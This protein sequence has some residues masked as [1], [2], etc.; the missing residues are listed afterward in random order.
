MNKMARNY[1]LPKD[2]NF[3]KANLHCHSTFSDGRFTVEKLK[4]I[5]M[6][7][8]YSIIAYS[9]HNTLTPHNELSDD[10]FLAI[11]SIEIDFNEEL[12]EKAP[13]Y[14]YISTYHINFFSKDKDRTEFIP[15]DRVY[16]REN[17]KDIIRRANEAG[18][19]VQYNHPRWSRQ[20]MED[21]CDLDGL[22]AF[23]VL[24]YG[25]ET[26][27]HNGWAD[28]EYEWFCKC[29]MK[30]AAVATDDNHNF[31]N[32]ITSP[33]NDSFGG[34]TMIKAPSLNYDDILAAMERKDC[35]A[36]SGPEIH[37]I[38]VDAEN[39]KETIHVSCSGVS[40]L[41]IRS[42][43]RHTSI[44]RSNA[45]DITSHEATF[46]QG[47]KYFRIECIDSMGR[48]AMSRAFYTDEFIR[49]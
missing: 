28:F 3:Y 49:D 31:S 41:C 8:G 45:D 22:F 6:D 5:Y 27:M 39:G 43:S 2:G 18:F 24:N 36:S 46:D 48:K 42:E 10:K 35:Y 19:L 30:A 21:F 11:N 4:E 25:C 12:S 37:E 26:E 32:D 44:V 14:A 40:S 38:Y 13:E 1:I 7:K 20:T 33:Y 34:W 15:F 9:D 16:D 17:I 29:G 23:E 47:H